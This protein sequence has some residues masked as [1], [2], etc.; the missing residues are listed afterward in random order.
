MAISEAT[1]RKIRIRSGER[2]ALLKR[3]AIEKLTAIEKAVLP[4]LSAAE[5]GRGLE[6][7]DDDRGAAMAL[8]RLRSDAPR[9]AGAVPDR[10]TRALIDLVVEGEVLLAVQA[11]TMPGARRE[12]LFCEAAEAA[13]LG[14]DWSLSNVVGGPVPERV[15]TVSDDIDWE[16][17]SLWSGGAL[18]APRRKPEASPSARRD[19]RPQRNHEL[20]IVEQRWHPSRSDTG[21]VEQRRLWPGRLVGALGFGAMRLSTAAE[22]PSESDALA[23]LHKAWD[24]GLTFVDTADAYGADEAELGHNERLIGR[25]RELWAGDRDTLVIGTKGGMARPGGRWVPDGRPEHLRQACERSL[26][27]L[28]VQRIDLYQLHVRDPRVPWDE[29]IGALAELVREGKLAHLGLCNVTVQELEEAR[30]LTEIVSVQNVCNPFDKTAFTSGMVAHCLREGLTFIAHSPLGGHRGVARTLGHKGIGDVAWRHAVT[31]PEVVLAWLLSLGPHL[32][33]IFGATQV[34]RVEQAFHALSLRLSDDDLAWLDEAF[35]FVREALEAAAASESP[36]QSN[37]VEGKS[38]QEH[39]VY[40]LSKGSDFSQR[41]T[42]STSMPGGQR[43]AQEIVMTVGI[44]GAGKSTFVGPLVEQGYVRLNRD[45]LGGTL[46]DLVPRLDALVAS[47]TRRFVLDNTYATAEARRGI[48]AA[49][50]A[51]ALP[52]RAL[53]LDTS[54]DD[55]VVNVCQRMLVNHG[56]LL[57]PE[58]LKVVGRKDPSVFPPAVVYRF[59]RLFEPPQLEEGFAFVERQPF[60]RR[61]QGRNKAPLLDLDGTLRRT[62]SG[63]PFPS[64]PDDVEILPNRAEVLRRWREDGYRLLGVSNQ[65]GVAAGRLDEAAVRACFKRTS[66]LLGLDLEIAFCPHEAGAPQCYCRKPMPGLGV[67]FIDHYSLD[68][69]QTVM[70]GDLDTDAEF[71]RILGLRYVKATEFFAAANRPT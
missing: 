29:S 42:T 14:L 69:A 63:A 48:L 51:H 23:L 9:N 1:K 26:K 41:P 52:V 68:R 56:R 47:G 46:A 11:A 27:A 64:T 3:E 54:V 31:N 53:W 67:Q 35:P 18:P 30:Q 57:S 66:E 62:K 5:L 13:R 2:L 61:E 28:G 36:T 49:A 65:S 25:A 6:L 19:A 59:A 37:F 45:T 8:G 71:A 20:G 4:P 16:D 17:A 55:A 58:E 38:P 15:S 24:T 21:Q 70:V 50:R 60:L 34:D 12:V 33:P 43:P 22:R 39:G 40:R 44:Q 32:I 7:G 10:A